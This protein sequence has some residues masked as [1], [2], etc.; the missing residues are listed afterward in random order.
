MMHIAWQFIDFYETEYTDNLKHSIIKELAH[1]CGQS[2][3]LENI[4]TCDQWC[5]LHVHWS[6]FKADQ[7]KKHCE[8]SRIEIL[9]HQQ[10]LN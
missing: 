2:N 7:L 4:Y 9:G 5:K 3:S 1:F 10:S 6:I 8:S